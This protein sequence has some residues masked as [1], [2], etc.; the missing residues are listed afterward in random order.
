MRLG[1]LHFGGVG[2]SSVLTL[3]IS[4]LF[5]AVLT[6]PA[7]H[8]QSAAAGPQIPP[9]VGELIDLLQDP[10]VRQWLE[11]QQA[12]PAPAPAEQESGLTRFAANRIDAVQKHFGGMAAAL[13]QLPSEFSKAAARLRSE[14]GQHGIAKLV[15]WLAVFAGLGWGARW[16]YWRWTAG[17]RNWLNTARMDSTAER[18][19]ALGVR[20]I[21]LLG[22]V[23][24]FA[25]GSIGAFMLFG[26]PPML[27]QLLL[28]LIFA[29]VLIGLAWNLLAILLAPD[30]ESGKG[31]AERYR[32]LSMT[33]D[34]AAWWTSRLGLAATW[35]AAGYVVVLLL[36]DLGFSLEASRLVAYLLGL[37][38]LVIGLEMVWRR[39]AMAVPGQIGT[40][41]GS[42][43]LSAYFVLLWLLWVASAAMLFW[44]A[45]AAVALPA[46]MRM[47]R[48]AVNH[49]FRPVESPAGGAG[50]PS[51]FGACLERALRALLI[52]GAVVGLA[53]ALEF[54]LSS[55]AAQDSFANRMIRGAISAAVILLVADFAWH[56]TKTVIDRAVA[57]AG[58]PG[59]VG[60]EEHRRRGRM[61]TLL[62]I[63][64]NVLFVTFAAVAL[65]MA[66]SAL[67]VQVAPLIAGAG[68]VGVAVGFGAQ[69]LVKDVISGMFYL[70]DDAFRI[71]EYIES[72][73]YKGTV[74][75]FS[76]RSIKLR[77]HRGP[78]FTVPFG[79]LGAV[80]NMS[81]DWVIDKMLIGVTYDSDTEKARK[82]IRT[83][84]QELLQDPEHGSHIIE[85]LKMKGVDSFGDY[86]VQLVLKMKTTPGEQSAIR[87]VA[88]LKIKEAFDKNGIKFAFP[89]VQVA[90]GSDP[91]AA[92]ARQILVHK[93][94]EA[95]SAP[96]G[97]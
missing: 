36:R 51:V 57:N 33:G 88:Y 49:L 45:V 61:R 74:E 22:R 60:T 80:Q 38:L 97:G 18:L 56:I 76:I 19:L 65:L 83:I 41:R 29:V 64:R 21:C 68:V 94:A 77:H 32:I 6:N 48:S 82:L 28:S 50:A 62:P 79:A 44:L 46:A 78:V 2:S 54:D 4:L 75:S 96:Q 15:F 47:T 25:I 53:N 23:V 59:K 9:K 85:P 55:L 71:G 10:A 90:G 34:R 27:R 66:L 63:V 42:W 7:A 26:W 16:L 92:A 95:A 52:G 89:T 37:G 3:V 5:M 84:G 58:D 73:S 43:L 87:R 91:A 67:G 70:L 24:A 8:A 39:P 81:R 69:T 40:D 12:M 20:S 31:Q 30:D 17:L 35:F 14:I 13:P 1:T 72:G 11:K 86:A 93:A